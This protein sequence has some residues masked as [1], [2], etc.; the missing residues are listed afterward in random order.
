MRRVAPCPALVGKTDPSR[1]CDLAIAAV[2]VLH[3]CAV[4]HGLA[5]I[6]GRHTMTDP[7]PFVPIPYV[8]VFLNRDALPGG[9]ALLS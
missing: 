3:A 5:S 2:G 1:I 8:G 6:P 7:S 9:T 4:T